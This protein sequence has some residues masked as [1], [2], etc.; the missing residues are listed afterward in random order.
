MGDKT[1]IGDTSLAE[2]LIPIS[3]FFKLQYFFQNFYKPIQG[4]RRR[5]NKICQ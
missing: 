4:P 5:K 2:L 3:P 1:K